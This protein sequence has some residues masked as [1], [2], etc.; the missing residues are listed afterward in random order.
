MSVAPAADA[1]QDDADAAGGPS[2]IPVHGTLVVRQES[3]SNCEDGW[4]ASDTFGSICAEAFLFDLTV[5]PGSGPFSGT[6]SLDYRTEL[7]GHEEQTW[8]CD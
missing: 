4:T 5:D 3:Q 6:L 8:H 2:C 1:G 7:V